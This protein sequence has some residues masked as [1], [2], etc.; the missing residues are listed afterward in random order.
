MQS[1]QNSVAFPYANHELS[2]QKIKQQHLQQLQKKIKSSEKFWWLGHLSSNP[3]A[4]PSTWYL[5][6]NLIL[7]RSL[8]NL[9]LWTE[10]TDN[11]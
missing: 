11:F 6:Y 10:I 2:G 1:L 5:E 9:Y 4:N 8:I 7:I 3:R